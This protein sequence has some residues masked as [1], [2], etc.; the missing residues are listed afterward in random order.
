MLVKNWSLVL[1]RAD[2]K[3][4]LL[5]PLK[6]SIGRISFYPKWLYYLVSTIFSGVVFFSALKGGLQSKKLAILFVLPL[7]LGRDKPGR[8]FRNAILEI[9]MDTTGYE[10]GDLSHYDEAFA[11]L[12]QYAVGIAAGPSLHRMNIAAQLKSHKF[13]GAVVAT[14]SAMRYCLKQGIIPDLVVSLD[15]HA[16]RIV[17]W[18]GDPHLTIEDLKQDDYFSRQDMDKP[19]SHQFRP[20]N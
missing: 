12:L 17:R 1:G 2:I 19:F 8:E 16:K 3:N 20:N 15:P 4:L 13:S 18:F 7:I 5:I 10:A 14:E 11:I 6:F 9:G